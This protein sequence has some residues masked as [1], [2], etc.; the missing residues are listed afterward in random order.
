MG[1]SD[2]QLKAAMAA[3]E[4]GCLVQTIALNYDVLRST[5]RSHIMGITLSRKHEREPIL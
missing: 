2:Q 1:T 5:L 4:K 3:V